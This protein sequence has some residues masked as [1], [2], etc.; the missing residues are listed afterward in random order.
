MFK[1][2]MNT[3]RP[4][5]TWLRKLAVAYVPG[6]TTPVLEKSARKLLD[7]FQKWGHTVQAEP[8][9]ETDVILT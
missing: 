3:I 7:Q 4:A 2:H 5:H 8:D 6:P 9:N 1:M